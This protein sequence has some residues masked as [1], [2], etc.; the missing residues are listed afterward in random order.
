MEG[1]DAEGEA[2]S[3]S[4]IQKT[5]V[6]SVAG[7]GGWTCSALTG[8]DSTLIKD[9]LSPSHSEKGVSFRTVNSQSAGPLLI[10]TRTPDLLQKW[11]YHEIG[12]V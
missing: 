8:E 3:K 7:C 1:S 4:S 9:A 6:A 5:V 12:K 11:I 2:T 10:V